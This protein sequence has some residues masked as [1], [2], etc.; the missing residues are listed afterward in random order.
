MMRAK[1]WSTCLNELKNR[2]TFESGF[3]YAGSLSEIAIRQAVNE[4]SAMASITAFPLLVFPALADEKLSEARRW[5]EK[6]KQIISR[7]L[8]LA[9]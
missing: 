4:A 2:L 6:Q 9:A 5:Q 3:R 7:P 8:L 1:F